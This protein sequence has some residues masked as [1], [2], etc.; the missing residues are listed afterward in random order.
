MAANTIDFTEAH[1]FKILCF[2]EVLWDLLPEGP[3]PGG[4]PVNVALHLKKFGLNVR[5]AG[6]IGNDLLG[7]NLRSFI[8]K[9]GLDTDLLQV[10]FNLPTSTVEVQLDS[11][12]QPNFTIVDNVAW[13]RI[14]LTESLEEAT[15][16]S[17][18]LIYGTLASRHSFTRR[19]LLSMVRKNNC[20]RFLDVN[21]RSPYDD[22]DM[23]EELIENASIVKLN[24]GE[25][26]TIA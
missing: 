11:Y 14:E 8:E 22:K 6:R 3:R 23:V 1:R 24:D 15:C 20:L 19:T 2:G 7:S 17:D 9:Q 16:E 18:I 25:I 12:N 4:A 26:Q 10:D 21:L 13:D 5:F